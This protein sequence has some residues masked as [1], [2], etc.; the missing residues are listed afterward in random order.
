MTMQ[1]ELRRLAGLPNLALYR[2]TLLAAARRIDAVEA[3]SSSKDA[4]VRLNKAGADI[5]CR[6]N[7]RL[8]RRVN[9]LAEIVRDCAACAEYAEGY[10]IN[11]EPE[12]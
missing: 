6:E 2:D 7:L 12:E 4:E 3:E 10:N 9:E 11:T 1:T 5:V 8:K